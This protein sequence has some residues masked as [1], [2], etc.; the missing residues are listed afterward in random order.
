[1]RADRGE[2]VV[3]VLRSCL[4]MIQV[5]IM[6]SEFDLAEQVDYTPPCCSIAGLILILEPKCTDRTYPVKFYFS[7]LCLPNSST[8]CTPRT[9]SESDT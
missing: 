1:M 5:S 4:N 9:R 2:C 7:Q 8:S 6:R 3:N